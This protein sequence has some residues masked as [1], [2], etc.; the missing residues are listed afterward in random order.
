[1]VCKF[2]EQK[3]GGDTCEQFLGRWFA[4]E[5]D[6]RPATQPM[7]RQSGLQIGSGASPS[8]SRRCNMAEQGEAT[9]PLEE[10][11]PA[12]RRRLL[13]QVYG[14]LVTLAQQKLA[15]QQRLDK[16]T[17]MANDIKSAPGG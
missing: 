17:Q 15:E 16:S 11:S 2:A 6:I 12:E 13:G 14:M 10:I 1:M 7:D 8:R 4:A 9:I 3:A 5:Y